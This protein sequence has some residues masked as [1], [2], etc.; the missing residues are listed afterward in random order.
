MTER[1]EHVAH[2]VERRVMKKKK[3]FLILNLKKNLPSIPNDHHGIADN[4]GYVLAEV[5]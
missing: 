5:P 3:F 4:F 1:I 2:P